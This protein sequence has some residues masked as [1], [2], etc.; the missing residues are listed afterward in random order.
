MNNKYV[1]L[2][3][4]NKYINSVVWNGDLSVW[5]PPVGTTAVPL[6]QVSSDIFNTEKYTAEQW[7]TKS[8]YTATRLISLLD[9]EMKLTQ[10]NKTADKMI[11]V[12]QWLNGLL[13]VF[14]VDTIP[15]T[16]WPGAP[17]SYEDTI[18]EALAVLAT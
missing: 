14:A 7:I 1:I 8:G 9:L 15:H 2:D 12:R 6:D 11:A 10:S 4:N 18:Q 16:T 5:Q 3:S 17:Y 13:Q